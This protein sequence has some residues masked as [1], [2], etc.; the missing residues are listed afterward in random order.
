MFHFKDA[1]DVFLGH[2]QLINT[3]LLVPSERRLYTGALDGRI[4][5]YDTHDRSKVEEFRAATA[6]SSLVYDEGTILCAVG[7]LVYIVQPGTA[8][9]QP[10]TRDV[11]P[12]SE[13]TTLGAQA[14]DVYVGHADGVIRWWVKGECRKQWAGKHSGAIGE[15]Y[16]LPKRFYS[17]SVDG[18]ALV[19]N[20]DSVRRQR[21][22]LAFKAV[23]LFEL[24]AMLQHAAHT[25]TIVARLSLAFSFR[26]S[27][28]CWVFS[29]R[30]ATKIFLS[31]VFNSHVRC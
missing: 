3:M 7:K 13:V 5:A 28:Y 30:C 6:V 18:S 22:N 23:P 21:K 4:I 17:T 27:W 9:L 20:R 8:K 2:K 16:V 25:I 12:S 11:E 10:V 19:W 1:K 14:G 26:L 15:I 24:C 29:V 31:H